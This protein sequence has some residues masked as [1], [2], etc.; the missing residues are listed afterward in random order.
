MTPDGASAA[1][2]G[3]PK[4]IGYQTINFDGKIEEAYGITIVDK[5]EEGDLDVSPTYFLRL[6]LSDADDNPV[7]VNS[8]ALTTKKDV[9]RYQ[10]KAWNYTPQDEFADFTHLQLLDE[11]DLEIVGNPEAVTNGNEQTL[12]Y[13]V[14]N[15]GTSIAYAVFAK[16]KKGNRW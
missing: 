7:S 15:N 2:G 4:Q 10:N 1:V 11:V 13:T 16:I 14:K 12:T 5:V 9:M 8:Y 6:E 3:K